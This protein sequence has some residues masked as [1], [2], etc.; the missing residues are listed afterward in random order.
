LCFKGL[1]LLLGNK[2]AS[3]TGPKPTDPFSPPTNGRRHIG[4]SLKHL[5]TE[6]CTRVRF[7]RRSYM[8]VSGKKQVLG[9]F[10]FLRLCSNTGHYQTFL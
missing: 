4:T 5:V 8:R 7:V 2:P 3:N 6:Y 1:L 10:L 9:Y